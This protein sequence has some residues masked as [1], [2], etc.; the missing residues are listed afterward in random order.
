MGANP[1]AK[2]CAG[3]RAKQPGRKPWYYRGNVLDNIRALEADGQPWAVAKYR[4]AA[5]FVAVDSAVVYE[6]IIFQT[7]EAGECYDTLTMTRD[8][9]YDLMAALGLPLKPRYESPFGRIFG[10]D[11]RLRDIVRK[12]QTL[13]EGQA[14]AERRLF[15]RYTRAGMMCSSHPEDEA[16]AAARRA[17][18]IAYK[19]AVADRA[20]AKAAFLKENRI[21]LYN[22]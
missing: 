9:F 1:A 10:R 8:E 6:L 5:R 19:T 21:T 2:K 14:E 12:W 7:Y 15:A 4:T 22:F 11:D 16:L 3:R 20:S 13:D 17:A 18:R